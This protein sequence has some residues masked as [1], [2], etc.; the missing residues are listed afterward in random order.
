MARPAATTL[1]TIDLEDEILDV[2]DCEGYWTIAYNGRPVS[3][4]KTV[5]TALGLTKKYP[6]TGFN[7]HAH[8]ANLAKKLNRQFNTNQFSCV[9]L[10]T[11]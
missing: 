4:R 6:R 7:N 2:L 5:Y 3:L 1:L 10:T 8:C 11:N 9:E